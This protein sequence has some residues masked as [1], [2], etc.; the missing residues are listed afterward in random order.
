DLVRS[1][2][3]GSE[4]RVF[5]DNRLLPRRLEELVQFIRSEP[6]I[7]LFADLSNETLRACLRALPSVASALQADVADVSG[8]GREELREFLSD[9][10]GLSQRD[11]DDRAHW[12]YFKLAVGALHM[13]SGAA[14]AY[15]AESELE[16][17]AFRGIVPRILR[18][19]Y[20]AGDHHD[21]LTI[22]WFIKSVWDD[23]LLDPDDLDFIA[24]NDRFAGNVFATGDH[25]RALALWKDV[26]HRRKRLLGPDH[27]RTI[28][29]SGNLAACLVSLGEFDQA[30]ELYESS[31]ERGKQELGPEHPDVL[32]LLGNF[33]GLHFRHKRFEDARGLQ[34]D[35]LRSYTRALGA[36]HRDTLSAANNLAITLRALRQYA[37]AQVLGEATLA[38][39]ER[40]LGVEH[41]HTRMYAA[42]L[43]LTNS[44]LEDDE[45]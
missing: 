41:P 11:P 18:Y 37:A 44:A 22:G 34:S 4:V 5:T 24:L 7:H 27:Q 10:E 1:M 15:G 38:R 13:L 36:D 29:S 2:E 21:G 30:Q 33:A 26:V 23:G 19:T 9:H 31:I 8:A 43:E 28:V 16:S 45:A 3:E 14:M 32:R 42:S 25:G 20:L 39:A 40:T 6:A 17:K 12:G 35:L